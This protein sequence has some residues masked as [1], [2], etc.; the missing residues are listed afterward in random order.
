MPSCEMRRS[1]R[2]KA[3]NGPAG[4]RLRAGSSSAK[5]SMTMRLSRHSRRPV[6]SGKRPTRSR[7]KAWKGA[8][9]DGAGSRGVYAGACM[10]RSRYFRTV[11]RSWPVRRA[12]AET[13]SPCR[14]RSR[15]MTS[16]PRVTTDCSHDASRHPRAN[17]R[18]PI[19]PG[20]RPRHPRAV[21]LNWGICSQ[22]FWGEFTQKLQSHALR[23]ID[24]HAEWQVSWVFGGRPVD[25]LG[26]ETAENRPPEANSLRTSRLARLSTP[27]ETGC[28][29]MLTAHGL[30][31]PVR[32][33]TG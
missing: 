3:L 2:S 23:W 5:C 9:G 29:S 20:A 10:P 12:M 6:R 21:A 4:S 32:Q 22:H 27:T 28:I 30:T 33:P 8:S 15:I 7:R 24:R 31:L 13:D 19:P 25:W 11:L 17:R 16:S 1:R 14:T 26:A 18:R